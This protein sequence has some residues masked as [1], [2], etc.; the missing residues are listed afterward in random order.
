[1]PGS[2]ACRCQLDSSY[3]LTPLSPRDNSNA[4]IAAPNP[5]GFRSSITGISIR[6]SFWGTT[7]PNADAQPRSTM[8]LA[9]SRFQWWQ[10]RL[11]S[12]SP[13][14][15]DRAEPQSSR[16]VWQYKCISGEMAKCGTNPAG[17]TAWAR[18]RRASTIS[19][20]RRT[21]VS[22]RRQ[23]QFPCSPAPCTVYVLSCTLLHDPCHDRTTL[24]STA[25]RCADHHSVLITLQH[26]IIHHAVL[27]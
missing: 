10:L 24:V 15:G 11:L 23:Q 1:M 21:K 13:R 12:R 18:L 20:K 16:L 26:T 14:A 25:P 7:L 3:Q 5:T 9:L 17:R 4:A 27:D 6:Q 19:V 8:N 2:E 22:E